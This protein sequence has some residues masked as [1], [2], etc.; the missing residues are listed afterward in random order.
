MAILSVAVEGNGWVLAVTGD[1][2]ATSG[3]WTGDPSNDR[4]DGQFADGS[5]D[6]FPLDP[7]GAPKVALSVVRQG[8]A[9]GVGGVPSASSG[10]VQTVVATKP[11]RRP[12][13]DQGALDE[14]DHGDGTRTVRLALSS[15]I[16]DGDVVSAC[17][18]ASGW[19]AGEGADTLAVSNN[20]TFALQGAISRFVQPHFQLVRGAT[21]FTAELLVAS[22]HPRHAGIELHQAVAAVALYASDGTTTVGPFWAS[23]GDSDRGDGLRCWRGELD[24]STLDPGP[25]SIFH[26]TYPWIG[27]KREQTR[28]HST[29]ATNGV[30]TAWDAPLMIC[31]DPDGDLY[32]NAHVYVDAAAGSADPSLVTVGASLALAKA[33]TA[34]ADVQTALQAIYL[35]NYTLP[36]RNGWAADTARAADWATIWLAEGVQ[37]IG[38]AN[39]SFGLNCNEGCVAIR[40]EM[41]VGKTR[42]DYILRTGSADHGV[43]RVARLWFEDLTVEQGEKNWGGIPLGHLEN[44]EVRGKS[45]FETATAQTLF[46][47]TPL[48]GYA[49]FSF[50][51]STYWKWGLGAGTGNSNMRILLARSSW[52][53]RPSVGIVTV[54]C[55][56][57]DDGFYDRKAGVSPAF[58]GWNTATSSATDAMLWGNR[59]L[60]WDGGGVGKSGAKESGAG[61]SADPYVYRRL[62]VVNNVVELVGPTN[63]G[64]R[65]FRLGAVP[66]QLLDSVIEGNTFAGN[67]FNGF[68]DGGKDVG[69]GGPTVVLHHDGNAVRNNLFSRHVIKGDLFLS[70]GT[71]TGNWPHLY[72]VDYAANLNGNQNSA[73]S[74]FQYSFFGVGS[75]V[76]TDYGAVSPAWF[77]FVDPQYNDG[78]GWGDYTPD[79]GSRLL[80]R[81]VAACIDVDAYGAARGAVHASG[82]VEGEAPPAVQRVGA[83]STVHEL[84]SSEPLLSERRVLRPLAARIGVA[85]SGGRLEAIAVVARRRSGRTIEVEGDDRTRR[86]GRD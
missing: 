49:H 10:D 85:D 19:K 69:A 13:P 66:E 7:S 30:P 38:T 16:Y 46:N 51:R 53:T 59:A 47:T 1:W 55:D 68:Y 80:G 75:Q 21:R 4:A 5:V 27:V 84:W 25:V 22:Q 2:G 61:T 14:T 65:M 77:G 62:A 52:L 28:V 6:Q 54:N 36:A 44:V 29:D 78:D 74:T 12:Y 8:F 3:A 71:L 35:Q 11:L 23:V 63:A 48:A 50:C 40:G 15:R 81:G 24:L 41:A 31:Y 56:K 39:V 67:G 58:D 72:G 26:S 64:A 82:A 43:K 83:S 34:A 79:A 73:P 60:A 17:S 18:F 20:S 45:G 76:D 70:D 57:P 33:G 42:G 9:R 86:A 37:A 32:P